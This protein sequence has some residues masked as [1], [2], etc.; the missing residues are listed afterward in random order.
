MPLAQ[1]LESLW[2]FW[3]GPCLTLSCCCS[4]AKSCLT[5]QPHELQHTEPPCLHCLL[6]FAQISCPGSR[7]CYLSISSSVVPFSFCLQS[8]PAS[9]SFPV[10]QLFTSQCLTLI[11]SHQIRS[12]M[13]TFRWTPSLL[14]PST[15][16]TSAPSYLSWDASGSRKS[17]LMLRDWSGH[18]SPALPQYTAF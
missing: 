16:V 3:F 12:Y 4:V 6:E 17:S 8:F 13:W 10:S 14:F 5:L 18:P 2:P 9:G 11:H 7:W 1:R 15:W